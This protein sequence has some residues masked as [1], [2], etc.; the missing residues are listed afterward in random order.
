MLFSATI[1]ENIGYGKDGVT[2]TEIEQAAREANAYDFIMELP[3]VNKAYNVPREKL[4]FVHYISSIFIL[5]N[6][7]A[8]ASS[9]IHSLSN[10]CIG[11]YNSS[12]QSCNI[13]SGHIMSDLLV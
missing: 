5:L 6:K 12:L 9:T 11:M 10:R 8:L 7:M 2:Q 1:A 13:I 3:Q 4:V